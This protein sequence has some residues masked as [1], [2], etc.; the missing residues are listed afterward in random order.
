MAGSPTDYSFNH[1]A[2]RISALPNTAG[3]NCPRGLLHFWS[4]WP[5]RSRGPFGYNSRCRVADVPGG[6]SQ[7]LFVGEKG[8]SRLTYEGPSGQTPA[9]PVE[10]PWAMAAVSYF[11]PQAALVFPI[12]T[13][14]PAPTPS[15]L[16]YASRTVPTQQE[17]SASHSQ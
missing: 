9:L 16:T 17:P 5:S 15:P 2:D 7:T 12:P 13:G 6:T 14:S 10:Y 11:A 1:G 4:D 3:A 8:G